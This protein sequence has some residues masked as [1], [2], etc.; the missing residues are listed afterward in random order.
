M[1]NVNDTLEARQQ[2]RKAFEALK[3]EHPELTTPEAQARLDQE[4]QQTPEP[5]EGEEDHA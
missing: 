1:A 2:F 4:L 3:A 5:H